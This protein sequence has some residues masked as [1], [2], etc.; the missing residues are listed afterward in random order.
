V[1]IDENQR[2]KREND[3]LRMQIIQQREAVLEAERVR[4]LASLK[5]AGLGRQ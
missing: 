2:L 5:D 3:E 1:Y 4:G